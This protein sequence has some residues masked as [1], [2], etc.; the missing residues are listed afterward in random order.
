MK[1]LLSG[2]L[3]GLILTSCGTIKPKGHFNVGFI[4]QRC[5]GEIVKNE[6][7]TEVGLGLESKIKDFIFNI[8]GTERTYIVPFKYSKY[9]WW[10]IPV[11]Q[12]FDMFAEIKKG[13]LKMYIEHMCAH[14]I[15]KSPK[16]IYDSQTKKYF[17]QGYGDLTEIGLGVEF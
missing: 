3:V 15:D 2:I 12:E 4:P 13:N 10:V 17:I 6:L 7:V 16:Q 1:K 11:R 5:N 14:Q 8:G 9:F